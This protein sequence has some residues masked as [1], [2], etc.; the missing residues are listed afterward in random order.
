MFEHYTKC[1]CRQHNRVVGNLL[2]ASYGWSRS[3]LNHHKVRK[4]WCCKVPSTWE[5]T[6]WKLL[7]FEYH[8]YLANY[9]TNTPCDF[10]SLTVSV[11]L[12][13]FEKK[14]KESKIME[15]YQRL[16]YFG[17]LRETGREEDRVLSITN[18]NYPATWSNCKRNINSYLFISRSLRT[19]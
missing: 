11:S 13:S 3:A 10:N 16:P 14:W 19:S 12:P 6:V 18:I 8:N 17:T 7:C 5:Q 1:L 2:P 9:Q 15:R 4:C